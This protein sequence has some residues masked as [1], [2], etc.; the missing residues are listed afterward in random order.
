MKTF[1]LTSSRTVQRELTV[2][3]ESKEAALAAFKEGQYEDDGEL[4]HN[5]QCD[6]ERDL[7]E[8]DLQIE[9]WDPA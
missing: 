7:G 8:D 1:V 6:F 2:E 3:A 9:E 5:V 4:Q